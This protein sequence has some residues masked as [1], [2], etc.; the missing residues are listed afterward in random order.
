MLL[1][2]GARTRRAVVRARAADPRHGQEAP[3]QAARRDVGRWSTS[4][5]AICLRRWSTSSRCSAGR[6]ATDQEAVHTRRA[7][8]RRSRSRASAAATRSSIPRSSTGS[9]SSTS[10]GLPADE[11][12]APARSRCSRE[13]GLW[14]DELRASERDVAPAASIDLLKPRA[15][16]LAQLVERRPAVPRRGDRARG[17]G[18]AQSISR[19]P[20]IRPPLRSA[21]ATRYEPPR[22]STP[23][24]LEAVLRATPSSIG[25]KAGGAHPRHT[26]RGHGPRRR[27]R[28]C[29]R[30]SSSSG[31]SARS[32]GCAPPSSSSRRTRFLPAGERSRQQWSSSRSTSRPCRRVHQ[33]E[34]SNFP[35]VRQT[36]RLISAFRRRHDGQPH[37][38]SGNWHSRISPVRYQPLSPSHSI[39]S[40]DFSG[41]SVAEF[42]DR[43]GSSEHAPGD[44]RKSDQGGREEEHVAKEDRGFA[45]MDR[46]KQ[47]EIASKGGKA[48]HQKGTAHE[49]TSEEARD[50]GRKGGIA[51]HRVGASRWRWRTPSDD[52][53]TSACIATTAARSAA[54]PRRDDAA[55]A[56]T[57]PESRERQRPPSA[58]PKCARAA[59]LALRRARC[60][61]ARQRRAWPPVA[62][63]D[64]IAGL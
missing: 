40:G 25:I 46:A 1:Y 47:R 28:G 54:M 35:N 27:A 48:A 36:F 51:S 30:C 24:T 14:R 58:S 59:P 39:T 37:L 10:P 61:G 49:W 19:T 22:P 64:M 6:R 21:G 43:V 16:T 13:A 20:G 31:A 29:S 7:D 63:P 2:R 45:S 38:I 17:G 4:A 9:T 15:R 57:C 44:E 11:L 52:G 32:G 26:R 41:T 53:R 8:R 56:P 5:T 33:P 12:A 55:I 3:E 50:A 18:G 62:S 42:G 34:R 23:A 60:F